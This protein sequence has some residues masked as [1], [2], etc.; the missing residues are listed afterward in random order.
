MN[1]INEQDFLLILLSLIRS[2]DQLL[3]TLYEI[4]I[5]RINYLKDVIFYSRT[6]ERRK[7]A[8]RGI[9]KFVEFIYIFRFIRHV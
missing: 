3:H 5:I 9:E 7:Q 1:V 6:Y 4:V 2:D 8:A